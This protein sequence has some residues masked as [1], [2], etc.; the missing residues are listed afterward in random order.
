MNID[1]CFQLG[2]I[3]KTHGVQGEVTFVLDVDNPEDYDQLESVFIELNGKLV[4][5]FITNFQLQREKAIVKLEDV[6]SFES[7]DKLVGKT[8]H[9]P[10]T[11]LPELEEDQFYYHDIIGYLI[12]DKEKGA[13]GTIANVY[14]LPHQDL[15]AMTYQNKEVLIP[16]TD[17]IV[18]KVIHKKQE[19]YVELP[20]GLLEIYLTE[21]EEKPDDEEGE[22]GDL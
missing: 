10:L 21:T 22:E 20:D 9:L 19:L 5:F 15:I 16:I 3:A 8:L 17:E 12:I 14:E 7:A 11:Q 18:T 2:Y 4:P 13:L 6:N 1:N